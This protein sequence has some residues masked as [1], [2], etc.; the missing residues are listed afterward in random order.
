V[1]FHCEPA[2]ADQHEA[3]AGEI[4]PRTAYGPASGPFD[5]LRSDRA[6]PQQSDHIGEWF[7]V[8]DDL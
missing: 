6:R 2:L 4:H 1:V 7:H 8:P 5:N 3:K